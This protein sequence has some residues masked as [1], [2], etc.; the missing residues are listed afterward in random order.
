M[1]SAADSQV[2]RLKREFKKCQKA[3]LKEDYFTYT[4]ACDSSGKEDITKWTLH[5]QGPE[6]YSDDPTGEETKSG[7]PRPSPYRKGMF[8][9]S[10]EFPPQYPSTPPR[11]QFA[12]KV[13]HPNIRIEDGKVCNNFWDGV[14][15]LQ[16][17]ALLVV[18][19]LRGLLA[20]PNYKDHVE[21]EPAKLLQSD[22]VEY[23]KKVM[24]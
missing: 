4:I 15:N 23:E 22:I 3:A 17:N 19:V 8:T 10:L 14:W 6:N 12:T 20:N 2:K 9:V 5:F 7:K 13:F 21:T 11:I 18:E 16:S 1:A 24:E